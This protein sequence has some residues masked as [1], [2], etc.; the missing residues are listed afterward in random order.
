MHN[1][2]NHPDGR[3]MWQQ[4]YRQVG[5]DYHRAVR[6]A[7]DRM[8]FRQIEWSKINLDFLDFYN[9]PDGQPTTLQQIDM[10]VGKQVARNSDPQYDAKSR[11][12]ELDF[13]LKL[14]L[15]EQHEKG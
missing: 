4:I 10:Q 3:E 2:N 7:I 15:L 13:A 8:V 6:E 14:I 9:T 11:Q 5:E 1:L 12:A